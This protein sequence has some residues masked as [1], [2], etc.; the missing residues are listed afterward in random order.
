MIR[1]LKPTSMQRPL[2]REATATVLHDSRSGLLPP[3]GVSHAP[4][5]PHALIGA[6]S[7]SQDRFPLHLRYLSS[8]A[9]LIGHAGETPLA[10][11]RFGAAPPPSTPGSWPTAAIALEQL[12]DAEV[13]EMWSSS[14]PVRYGEADGIQYATDG[15]LL[16]GVV[17][18]SS[19]I[20]N[21]DFEP[22]VRKIYKDIFALT[23]MQGCPH[24]LRMWNYCPGINRHHDGLENYQRF[25]HARSQAFQER[26]GSLTHLLPAASAIGA[27]QG[28]LVLYFIACR[29]AGIHRENPRQI[30]AY[31]YPPQYGR[32]SPSFA[33]ATLGHPEDGEFLFISGTAS[34]V[35]HQSLHV[36][37][38]RAQVD[39]T[40][41]NIEALVESTAADRHTRFRGLS[42]IDHLKVYLRHAP[43]MDIA[44]DLI[45]RRIGANARAL[46]LAGDICRRELLVEVEAVIGCR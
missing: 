28:P 24:L 40:L 42:D 13:V 21:A 4:F 36:G 26:Y 46:Y 9:E 18:D 23:E 6:R 8:A 44:R 15:E 45:Q 1:T 27:R 43:D 2:R 37:D 17:S 5:V 39:E 22:R 31:S 10:E 20:E 38:I 34:I 41:R 35:G 32:R 11:I 14:L 7:L 12:G 19:P 29:K 16:C 30:S 25:C 33:R 3:A